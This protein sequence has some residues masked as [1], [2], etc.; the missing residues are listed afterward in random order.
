M[1]NA[2]KSL[3]PSSYRQMHAFYGVL[4]VRRGMFVAV[5]ARRGFHIAEAKQDCFIMRGDP[6]AYGFVVEWCQPLRPPP[7]DDEKVEAPNKQTDKSKELTEKKNEGLNEKKNEELNEKKNEEGN[8]A[9]AQAQPNPQCEKE[10]NEEKRQEGDCEKKD[11][12][13][14]EQ[15]E[16]GEEEDEEEDDE[17]EEEA[18]RTY[19]RNCGSGVVVSQAV[20]HVFAPHEI[21]VAPTGNFVVLDPSLPDLAALSDDLY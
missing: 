11:E 14:E 17:E 9:P 5:R 2:F 12:K 3:I 15:E 13:E 8:A 4:C 18:R 19:W 1:L 21:A 16:D 6:Q 10:R 20:F 7:E